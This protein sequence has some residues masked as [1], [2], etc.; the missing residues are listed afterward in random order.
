MKKTKPAKKNL[1]LKFKREI[2]KIL[3]THDLKQLRGGRDGDGES[4][5]GNGNSHSNEMH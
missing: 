4:C 2:I 5:S 1:K 3:T